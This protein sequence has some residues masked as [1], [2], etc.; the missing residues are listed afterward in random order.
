MVQIIYDGKGPTSCKTFTKAFTA[1]FN[2]E[3]SMSSGD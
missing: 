1:R 3:A 2:D